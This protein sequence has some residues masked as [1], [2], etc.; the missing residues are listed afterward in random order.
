MGYNEG[1]L[2]DGNKSNSQSLEWSRTL[3]DDPESRLI[4]SS[5][6]RRARYGFSSNLYDSPALRQTLGTGLTHRTNLKRGYWEWKAFL[7]YGGDHPFA[8]DFSPYLRLEYGHFFTSLFYLTTG[9]EYGITS[10]NARNSPSLDFSK[11][12]CDVNVNLSW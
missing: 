9:C 7:E 6:F 5:Y 11:F 8:W 1:T 10:K 4:W 12:Q 3:R 2:T